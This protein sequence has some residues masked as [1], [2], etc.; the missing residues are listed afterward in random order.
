MADQNDR[1]SVFQVAPAQVR[2]LASGVALNTLAHGHELLSGTMQ[3]AIDLQ[4]IRVLS[5]NHN[6]GGY[7]VMVDRQL[8]AVLVRLDGEEHGDDLRGK[9]F[10]EAGFGRCH[11]TNPPCICRPRPGPEMG[12]GQG[13]EFIGRRS[14][15]DVEPNG[16][17]LRQGLGGIAGN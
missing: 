17:F 13:R 4:P 9:W 1:S 14:F 10:L 6:R 16:R 11:Q 8:A 3:T 2:A 7:L 15:G 5:N 12:R